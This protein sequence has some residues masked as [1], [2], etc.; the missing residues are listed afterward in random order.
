MVF[1][2]SRIS[3]LSQRPARQLESFRQHGR[4]TADNVFVDKIQGNVP[5]FE[6]PEAAKM[7]DVVTSQPKDVM[8]TVV[9]DSIDR[10][11]RS[12]KDILTTIEVFTANN[13]NLKSLKEGFET[14]TNGKVNPVAQIV[15]GVMGSIAE[16]ERGRIRERQAE[17]IA[18]ARVVSPG[19]YVGRK[20]G[21]VQTPQ[22]MIERYPI[23]VNKLKKGLTI[24]D[25][26]SITGHS[27]TTV[28][29]IKKALTL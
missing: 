3:S 15:I 5:F 17:G 13:I 1:Y 20:V 21:S 22:R 6:R 18:V 25:I 26:C 27:S 28:M 16:F 9:I 11:G 10:L 24:A 2:Y 29:K 8:V 7:F 14:L 19:K 4:L 23:V 12:L